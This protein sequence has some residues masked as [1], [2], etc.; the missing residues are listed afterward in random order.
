MNTVQ[1]IRSKRKIEA[2]RKN[3]SPMY[4]LLFTIGIN[5]ALRVSD[6]LKLKAGDLRGKDFITVTEQKTGKK[7]RF[8]INAAIKREL[9]AYLETHELADDEYLFKSPR[10]KKP[11][12]RVAVWKALNKAARE[13]GI[14]EELGTHSLRKTFCWH[15]HRQGVSLA[16]LQRLLGHSHPEITMRYIGIRD[17]EINEVYDRVVL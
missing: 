8:K 6:L 4:R 5:S 13:V 2:M 17:D 10:G 12:S 7:R 3:L 16:T 11:L 14:E 15:A 1:P 9:K